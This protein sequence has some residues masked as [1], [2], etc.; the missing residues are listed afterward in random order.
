MNQIGL[1]QISET[2]QL[3]DKY[4]F[5]AGTPNQITSCPGPI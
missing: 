5:G 4:L 2:A 1:S 3:V